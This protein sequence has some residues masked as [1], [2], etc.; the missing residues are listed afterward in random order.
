MDSRLFATRI[1]EW[2]TMIAAVIYPAF[3]SELCTP[4]PNGFSAAEA[5]ITVSASM[6]REAYQDPF[7]PVRRG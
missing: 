7:S 5:L 2:A 4:G 3:S 1:H 6:C